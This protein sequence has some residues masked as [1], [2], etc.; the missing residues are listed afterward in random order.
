M[1][2]T[3]YEKRALIHTKGIK[4]NVH[5]GNSINTVRFCFAIILKHILKLFNFAVYD[6]L[7]WWG[8]DRLW[9]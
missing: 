2:Y 3:G 7:F 5:T 1:T 8:H 9:P 6:E 4:K